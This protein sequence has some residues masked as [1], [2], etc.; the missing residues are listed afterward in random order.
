MLFSHKALSKLPKCVYNHEE[1]VGETQQVVT[2]RG[3]PSSEFL[4]RLYVVMLLIRQLSMAIATDNADI[5]VT[6]LTREVMQL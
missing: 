6:F 2:H 5:V 4:R 3:I 1:E